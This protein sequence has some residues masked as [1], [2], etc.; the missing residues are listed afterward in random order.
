MSEARDPSLQNVHHEQQYFVVLFVFPSKG[1]RRCSRARA[2]RERSSQGWGKHRRWEQGRR[3][4]GG[5]GGR[6]ARGRESPNGI[7]E[8]TTFFT[9]I[10][11]I[12]S[13]SHSRG[14]QGIGKMRCSDEAF[15]ALRGEGEGRQRIP[16]RRLRW[17][18]VRVFYLYF[19]VENVFWCVR[20]M[21]VPK[22]LCCYICTDPLWLVPTSPVRYSHFLFSVSFLIILVLQHDAL[23][24][25]M[26]FFLPS[27]LAVKPTPSVFFFLGLRRTKT[28]R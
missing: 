17:G 14:M 15:C 3:S 24:W 22:Q 19:F 6:R 1:V 28:V 10:C 25:R 12:G 18:I 26:S 27:V 21:Y 13:P 7:R 23:R 11:N 4:R 8:I 16:R 9:T 2:D 5:G 20:Q